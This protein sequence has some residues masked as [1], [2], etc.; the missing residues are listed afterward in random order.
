[1]NSNTF[2]FNINNYEIKDLQNFFNIDDG[3]SEKDIIVSSNTFKSKIMNIS[4]TV[5]R[6]NLLLFIKK[7]ENFLIEYVSAKNNTNNKLEIVNKANK[8]IITHNDKNYVHSNPSQYFHGNLNPLNTRITHTYISIDSKFREN[9]YTSS[10]SDFYIHLPSKIKRVV[11]MQITSFELPISFYGISKSLGNNYFTIIITDINHVISEKH[12]T[13]PDGNYTGYSLIDYINSALCPTDANGNMLNPE[14]LFSYITF[15]L[16]ISKIDGTGTGRISVI[17]N[18]TNIAHYKLD[19][20]HKHNCGKINTHPTSR[21]GY[22]L[23]FVKE[24]YE[25]NSKYHS[26]SIIDIFPSRYIYL[27]IDDF[28]NNFS[29]LFLPVCKQATTFSSTIIAKIP[30]NASYFSLLTENNLKIITDERQYFGP[31]DIDRLRITL[32]D[33]YGNILDMNN[34][35]YSFCILIKKIY[36]L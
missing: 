21:C 30:I 4:D 3:Y 6:D 24:I 16:D 26:E 17:T 12:I 15:N 27:S 19:F 23:G 14:D 9:Y 11:S 2:D 8:N 10:S 28:N 22:I 33:E 5:F 18:N 7:A 31:V 25:K 13:I 29:Y 34:G 1:M 32:L 36:D 35:N 20:S